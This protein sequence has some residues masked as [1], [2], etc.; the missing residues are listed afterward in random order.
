MDI[1]RWKS[2]A[3]RKPTHEALLVLCGDYM[4]PASYV[5]KLVD[6]AIVKQAKQENISVMTWKRKNIKSKKVVAKRRKR[7]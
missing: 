5:E 1:S 2:I 7:S 4:G 3:I 6:E